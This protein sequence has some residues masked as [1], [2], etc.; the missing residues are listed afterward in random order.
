M[1]TQEKPD[2]PPENDCAALP[3]STRST[4][5]YR[6]AYP[7][8]RLLLRVI[9]RILAPR[10]KITGRYNVPRRGAVILAPNHISDCD[11]PFVLNGSI[12]PLWFMA[13]RELFEMRALGPVIRFCQAFAVEPNEA[14]RAALRFTEDLL[15]DGQAV[16]VFPEGR[17]A[18]D[19]EMLDI[20]SGVVLLALRAG[21]PIVPVGLWGTQQV[22]PYK[23]RV[24]RPTLAYVRVHFGKPLR[25]DDIKTLPRRQQRDIAAER[26]E[27][28]MRAARS[29][30]IK[31]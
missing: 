7:F 2:S 8:A 3:T 11:P 21:V 26:L 17:I 6:A 23:Q 9:A 20:S 12:R 28:A 4:A 16:V 19:G 24:P 30:A 25:F 29:I 18:P 31:G 13:K 14:D 1:S 15:R 10:L 5:A 22:I 27:K